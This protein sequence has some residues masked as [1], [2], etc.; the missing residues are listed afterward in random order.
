[1]TTKWPLI[2]RMASVDILCLVIPAV[3]H[4]MRYIIGSGHAPGVGD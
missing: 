4:D 1:M 2:S 3:Q